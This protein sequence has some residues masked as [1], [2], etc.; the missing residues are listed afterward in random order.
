MSLDVFRLRIFLGCVCYP[1][2]ATV[3]SHVRW[4]GFLKTYFE[5]F[6]DQTMMQYHGML[7]RDDH[8]TREEAN[9]YSLLSLLLSTYDIE[10]S[11]GA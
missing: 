4:D 5:T 1:K 11:K 8:M 9:S 6:I 3:V 2:A 7:I 10:S